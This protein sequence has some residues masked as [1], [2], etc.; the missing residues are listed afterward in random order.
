[1]IADEAT[2]LS[3]TD[4]LS[5]MPH[6]YPF[7]LVD[8]VLSIEEGP[9]PKSRVGRSIRAIK[10]VTMNEAFFQGHFPGNPV[11]PGVLIVES[12]AQAGALAYFKR[13]DPK[14]NI[15]IV[16]IRSA[17]F[18]KP[19]T[20]GDTLFIEGSVLKDRGHMILIGMRGKVDNEIV[21]EA[22]ILAFISTKVPK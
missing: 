21:A 8:R 18:R 3:T 19:V 11:M 4:I 1:M 16:N 13:T 2:G 20:P 6:R 22:E 15:A 10:Q 12:L 17:K 5:I 9:D 14:T 7:M